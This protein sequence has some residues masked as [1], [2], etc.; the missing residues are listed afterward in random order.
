M[1]TLKHLNPDCSTD[2]ILDV[3]DEDAGLIID[4]LIDKDQVN[5]INADL[6]PY[7]NVD[8][9]G[10]DEFTGFKTILTLFSSIL[11]SGHF[12]FTSISSKRILLSANGMLSIAPG[13]S[14]FL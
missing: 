6:N 9:F 1:A 7:L 14:S 13:A 3:L 8:V 2:E 5:K 11:I 12:L 10:R 4:N